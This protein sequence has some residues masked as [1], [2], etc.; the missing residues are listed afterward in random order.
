[1]KMEKKEPKPIEMDLDE[2]QY[3]IRE[4]PN[5]LLHVSLSGE[6]DERS[7]NKTGIE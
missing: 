7:Q 4:N 6:D 1:M 2:L 3:F 5:I